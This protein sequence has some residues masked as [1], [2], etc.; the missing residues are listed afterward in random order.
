MRRERSKTHA[1]ANQPRRPRRIHD[2][3]YDPFARRAKAVEP[4]LCPGCGAARARGRWTWPPAATAPAPRSSG[5]ARR[6]RAAGVA[7]SAMCPACQRIATGY[8]AAV[9]VGI[10]D[11]PPARR[12]EILALV[13][14][15]EERDCAEHPMKRTFGIEASRDALRVPTTDR[16]LAKSIAQALQGAF[17]G[18]LVMRA[19]EAPGLAQWTWRSEAQEPG[20]AAKKKRPARRKPA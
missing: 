17:G 4:T 15:V 16:R 1:A 2:E 20:G 18:K 6:S 10:G 5:S 8:P 12:R 14:H 3:A 9:V 11:F 19:A 13:R 7:A